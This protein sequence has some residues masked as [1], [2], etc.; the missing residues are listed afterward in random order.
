MSADLDKIFEVAKTAA[1]AAG[2][3]IKEI[4][5]S[6][7]FS[8]SSKAVETD[9]VTS[10]DLEAEKIIIGLISTAFP[11]DQ[12]LSEEFNSDVKDNSVYQKPLWII[13]PIDGTRNYAHGIPHC[14]VSIAYADKGTVLAAVVHCPFTS[15]TFSAVKGRGAFLNDRPI[16]LRSVTKL[17]EALICTGFAGIHRDMKRQMEQLTKVLSNCAELRR[18]GAASLDIC[19]LACGR[20]DGFYESLKPWDIA[21]ACL[22]ARE[23]GALTGHLHDWSPEIGIPKDLYSEEILVAGGA[24]FEDLKALLK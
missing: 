1:F 6:G 22:I 19:W 20:L 4:R 16:H 15:E 5:E 12:F 18:I 10:A 23:A 24:I 9:L 7:N 13:D 21:A 17:R 2:K 14:A 8:V 3:R 11:S